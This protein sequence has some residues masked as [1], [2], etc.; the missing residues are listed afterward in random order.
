M[1]ADSKKSEMGAPIMDFEKLISDHKSRACIL[2]VEIYPDD[3]FGNIRIVAASKALK[4][5]AVELFHR[6]FVADS[7]YYYYL[8]QNKNFEDYIYR[9]ARFGRPLHSYIRVEQM[10]LW[11]NMFLLPLESDKEGIGYCLYACDV[12]PDADSEQQAS[13]A[14]DTASSSLGIS[15]KLGNASNENFH[16]VLDEIAEDIRQV[17]SADHCC[18]ILRDPTTGTFSDM[19]GATHRESAL[20]SQDLYDRPD[21][22]DVLGTFGATIGDSSCVIVK[23]ENDMDWLGSINPSLHSLFEE[24]GVKSVVL[25]PLKHSDITLGY[26]WVLNY[27]VDDVLKVKEMLELS[28]LFISSEIANH[29]LMK[30]L[31]YLSSV[32]VLTGCKNRNA[33][34]GIVNEI[35]TGEIDMPERYAVI[36]ADLNGLKRVNDENGHDAGDRM[37]RTAASILDRVFYDCDLFRAGGDE[38]MLIAPGLTEEDIDGRISQVNDSKEA[39]IHFA[40]GYCHVEDGKDIR[41]AMRTADERMYLDKNE[42][43][44]QHP[45]LKYR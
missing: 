29:Q 22:N 16:Q 24:S 26:L 8:P 33:M 19:H 7:P 35:A 34:N 9:A 43:Y 18:I 38:F 4:A 10:G 44:S 37:L 39:D 3:S 30:Q 42:Y 11:V 41:K 23:N 28:T 13:L 5:D 2:S 32:D 17:G 40:F 15:I 45:E 27:N 36:L 12:S 6:S 14:A 20:N 1:A 21:F 25:F 31:E